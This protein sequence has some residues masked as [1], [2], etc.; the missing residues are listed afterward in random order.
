M[1][2]ASADTPGDA[3]PARI[4][5][6]DIP[7]TRQNGPM[8]TPPYERLSFLDTSFL[9]LESADTHMHV[10]TVAI[11]SG[12]GLKGEHG[13][14]DFDQVRR[15]IEGRLHLVPRY[16]Q[17][18]AWIP[19]EQYPVWV[20]DTHFNLDFH[21]RHTA[22]PRP[23]SDAQLQ[24]LAG[25]LMSQRLDREKPLW[26]LWFVEG[27]TDDRFALVA[28]VH[29]CMVDGMAGVD[30]MSMLLDLSPTEEVTPAKPWTPRPVPSGAEL[31]V[32]ETARLARV[33]VDAAKG[34]RDGIGGGVRDSLRSL[35]GSL[36]KRTSAMSA[37]LQSGWLSPS[38]TTPINERIG[39]NRRFTWA[40][41]PLDDV[42]AVRRAFGVS[43][44]DV[45]LATVAGALRRFLRDHRGFD[46]DGADLRAMV[47]VS[48]RA[49]QTFGASSNQVAMWL[50]HLPVDDADAVSRLRHIQEET[51]HLKEDRHAEG[52][53]AI[54]QA[55]SGTPTRMLSVGLR[56]AT[57]MRP[58]NL[59]VTNVP[60][61]QFP[62]FLGTAPMLAAYPL[63]PLWQHHGIGI[64]LFSYLGTVHWGIGTDWDLVPDTEVLVA[65]IEDAFAELLDAALA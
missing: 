18:L 65:C 19:V 22:L 6:T 51:T 23:G 32:G 61:P 31:V 62:L 56:A 35:T 58:F 12:E 59:T 21:L 37:S 14:L 38:S 45:L 9:A 43:V 41:I 30:L 44:N 7:G 17:R 46:T 33:A 55:S 4:V 54:V 42:K 24:A 13:G 25:R 63:V 11:F 16:R 39:P 52:A 2:P 48:V 64:A 20:D 3:T 57:E 26:E 28:K 15:R 27:L 8:P 34:L 10:G 53:A 40:R 36:S 29:H 50:V 5:T 47:P 60:G 1:S 49:D